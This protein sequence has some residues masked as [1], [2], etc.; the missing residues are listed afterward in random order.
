MLAVLLGH[1]I[2]YGR[3][4]SLV[5][6]CKGYSAFFH[7]ART[8]SRQKRRYDS[9][10]RFIED[11]K[12]PIDVVR[13]EYSESCHAFSCQNRGFES[14]FTPDLSDSIGNRCIF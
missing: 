13:K 7:N 10:L 9:H 12:L 5:E 2:R 1:H 3:P 11:D 6:S 4:Q 14:E 8:V